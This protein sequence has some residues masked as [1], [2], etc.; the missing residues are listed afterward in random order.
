[1]F[2]NNGASILEL[3]KIKSYNKGVNV[4]NWI[5]IKFHNN[6]GASLD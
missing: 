2:H 3:C 6:G 5:K 1:M 4:F